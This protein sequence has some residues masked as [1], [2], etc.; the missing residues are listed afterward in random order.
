MTTIWAR[1]NNRARAGGDAPSTKPGLHEF[2][3]ERRIAIRAN[4]SSARC[5]YVKRRFSW[6]PNETD[7]PFDHFAE[8]GTPTGYNWMSYLMWCTYVL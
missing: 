5:I 2:A 1:P 7:T 6:N 8:S 3:E 4:N